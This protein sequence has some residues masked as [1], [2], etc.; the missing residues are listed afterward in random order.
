MT[1]SPCTTFTRGNYKGTF[2]PKCNCFPCWELYFKANMTRTYTA[3][4]AMQRYGVRSVASVQG[5]K[6]VKALKRFLSE[7]ETKGTKII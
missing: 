3:A 2:V 4:L 7:Q 1:D 5:Y 6:Y